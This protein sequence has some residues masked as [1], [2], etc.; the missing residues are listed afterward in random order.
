M[1]CATECPSFSAKDPDEALFYGFNLS[2]L[3]AALEAVTS[4]TFDLSL[5][6]GTS[7]PSPLATVGAADFTFPPLVKQKLQAGT[8]GNTYRV[9]ATI[10]TNQ[11]RTLVVSALLPVRRGA[12]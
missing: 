11:G 3:L 2:E 4:A 6:A 12:C 7:D 8:V 1:A 9:R 10:G 5:V